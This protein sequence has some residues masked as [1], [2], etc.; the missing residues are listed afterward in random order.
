MKIDGA[1]L[2]ELSGVPQRARRLEELGFDGCFA[3]EG[4][5]EPFMPLLLA[6][7][8]S[9]RLEVATGLAIAFARTP[10]TVANL[11]HD[12]H[13]YSGGRFI[14]GLASQIKPHI[15]RRYG[16]TWSKP[17]S[18]MREF[19]QALRAI[20][21]CWNEDAPLRFEGEF[22]NHTLM[23]PMFKPAPSPFGAPRIM[24]GG[25]GP[26]MT[27]VAGEVADLMLVH[28]FHTERSLAELTLPAIRE[29]QARA[30]RDGSD[31]ELACQALIV[32][33]ETE[34]DYR[35]ALEAT[36]GQIAFYGSTPAYRRVLEAEGLGELQPELK[37]LTREGRWGDMSS[38]VTDELVEKI[39]LC[40]PPEAIAG[41]L[42]E[43]YGDI[44]GRVAFASPHPPSDDC[45]RTILDGVRAAK[46]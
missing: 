18:R 42:L 21:A 19:V 31:F 10:M 40:G 24:L 26:K 37:K 17:V 32:T 25:V 29:G 43:R 11:A 20:F 12:L 15:E 44:A 23:P 4:P 8:H 38:L 46:G 45:V 9:E 5:H 2:V 13:V 28:P 14:L 30:G 3:F 39:A 34:A 1:L 22:Y 16:A 27:A 6:A 7:E 36:R 35:T 33:G 41:R